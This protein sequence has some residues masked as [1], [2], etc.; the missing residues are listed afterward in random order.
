MNLRRS[1]H[2]SEGGLIQVLE[3]EAVRNVWSSGILHIC[4]YVSIPLE[5]SAEESKPSLLNAR[6]AR[7]LSLIGSCFV[8]GVYIITWT[9]CTYLFQDVFC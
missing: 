8:N 1:L 5:F 6:A 7:L 4:I 3:K 9:L 2:L